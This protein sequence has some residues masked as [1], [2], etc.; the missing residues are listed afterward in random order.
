MK[1]MTKSETVAPRH[2][3]YIG[4]EYAQ[5][6]LA[7]GSSL[8]VPVRPLLE[9]FQVDLRRDTDKTGYV[10]G[11]IWEGMLQVGIEWYRAHREPLPGLR[12]ASDLGIGGLGFLAFIM[13][14]S[15]SLEQALA[16]AAQYQK[17]HTTSVE[18][19]FRQ[20]E[21]GVDIIISPLFVSTD[22]CDE[23]CDT[24]LGMLARFVQQCTDHA[25]D[26]I[27]S[28]SFAHPAPSQARERKRFDDL[29]MCPIYFGA[30]DS[31]IRLSQAALNRPLVTADP[32]LQAALEQQATEKLRAFENDGHS[33]HT[34][35][36]R[37]LRNL[38]A[39]G[40]AS[41]ENL[42]ATLA[43]SPRTLQRR[44]A[45][46]GSS[47]RQL[48]HEVRMAAARD[49]L[50]STVLPMSTIAERLGFN[51]PQSFSRWFVEQTGN[52]PSQF[53]RQQAS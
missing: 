22:V 24:Y 41:K 31:H 48:L 17:L 29:F 51:D 21:D 52:P 33:A 10:P 1:T 14:T 12:V 38:R 43:V 47:Y 9:Q 23:V 13:E 26:A 45:L 20:T 25:R 50:E 27:L 16:A 8:G 49:Y 6:F 15:G 28:V 7:Y 46:L 18:V 4:L 5:K 32:S 2:R 53:R 11:H 42:A 35:M 39:E 44:L 3:T 19:R 30:R 34:R 40:R 37:E 36:H